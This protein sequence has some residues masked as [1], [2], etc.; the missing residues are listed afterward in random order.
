MVG[1]N[2]GQPFN[3]QMRLLHVWVKEA[4]KWVLVAHQTTRIP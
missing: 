3:A 4:G 1:M 2:K